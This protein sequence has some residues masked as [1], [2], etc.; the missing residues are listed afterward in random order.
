MF[1]E[2]KRSTV[3]RHPS[4]LERNLTIWKKNPPPPPTTINKKKPKPPEEETETFFFVVTKTNYIA[5]KFC[6]VIANCNVFNKDF[7]V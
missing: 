7:I 6:K 4:K 3:K 5:I 2:I 1:A